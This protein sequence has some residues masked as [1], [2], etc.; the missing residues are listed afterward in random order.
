MGGR[1]SFSA[2]YKRDIGFLKGEGGGQKKPR[3][4]GT[5]KFQGMSLQQIEERIRNLSHEELFAIDSDGNVIAAYRGNRNSV[6]FPSSLA[7]VEGA[8]VTHGHPKGLANFGGTFSFADVYNMAESKWAEHRATASGQGEMNYII[9]RT[10]KS[11]GSGLV[12]RVKSDEG[13]VT[14]RFSSTYRNVYDSAR[15]RGKSNEAAL[16]EARQKAV[17]SINAYW[18]EI[19]PKYGFEYVTRKGGYTYNR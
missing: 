15:N 2:T 9:R 18:K 7:K 12:E 13:S 17:G 16:H 1:G 14:Q 11:D 3:P 6:A 19:L 8:T 5:E 10:S 4:M